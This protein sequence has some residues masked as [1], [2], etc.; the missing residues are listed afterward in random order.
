LTV[1]HLLYRAGSADCSCRR[2]P[3]HADLTGNRHGVLNLTM[4]LRTVYGGGRLM[5]AVKAI[6]ILT[7]D[8]VFVLVTMAA[9]AYVTLRR[10]AWT[11]STISAG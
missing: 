2:R 8:L 9:I 6:A 3:A 1:V 5:A 7:I 4:A 10:F 11:F